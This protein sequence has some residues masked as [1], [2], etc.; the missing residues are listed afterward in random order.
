MG[1][2]NPDSFEWGPTIIRFLPRANF[3]LATTM[4]QKNCAKKLC[5]GSNTM[6]RRTL[7]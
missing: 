5:K 7:F 3:F 6:K 2:G 4:V 1:R